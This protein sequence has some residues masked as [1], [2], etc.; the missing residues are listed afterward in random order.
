M[1]FAHRWQIPPFQGFFN[2]SLPRKGKKPKRGAKP[3]G[4]ISHLQA[5]KGRNLTA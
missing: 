2:F 5:L 3:I 4:Y 1:G